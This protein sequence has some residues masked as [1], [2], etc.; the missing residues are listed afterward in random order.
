MAKIN[1]GKLHAELEAAGIEIS[2]CDS[3][4]NVWNKEGKEIQDFKDVQAVIK[5]HDPMPI[6]VET[7]EERVIRIVKKKFIITEKEK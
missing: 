3:T 5:K 6:P 2:G 4:G 1:S 7:E